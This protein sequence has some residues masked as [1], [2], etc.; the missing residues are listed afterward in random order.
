MRSV[1]DYIRRPWTTVLGFEGAC[2]NHPPLYFGSIV[3]VSLLTGEAQAARLVSAV[4]GSAAIVAV[5]FL[6]RRLVRTYA[7]LLASTIL[8]LAPLHIWYSRR[9]P[10]VRPRGPVRGA[11]LVCAHP[12]SAGRDRR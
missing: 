2:D 10:H 1:V 6:T 9:G 11:L 7:G 3:A 12:V 5:F 4:A 8:A